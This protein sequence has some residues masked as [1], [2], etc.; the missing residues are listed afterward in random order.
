LH[1]GGEKNAGFCGPGVK[2]T[3]VFAAK[4]AKTGSED[5]AALVRTWYGEGG[6]RFALAG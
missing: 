2:T 1:Q 4:T 5:G 3:S 6:V